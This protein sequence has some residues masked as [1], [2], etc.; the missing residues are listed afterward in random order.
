MGNDLRLE[1]CR[2][3]AAELPANDR[4]RLARHEYD[5]SD[6]IPSTKDPS[7]PRDVAGGGPVGSGASSGAPEGAVQRLVLGGEQAAVVL[8]AVDRLAGALRPIPKTP[9]SCVVAVCCA[10]EAVTIWARHRT[11]PL[12][13]AAMT[14]F[15][16]GLDWLAGWYSQVDLSGAT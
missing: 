4:G 14:V 7:I 6:L 11:W 13:D 12:V 1:R 9:R 15:R 5:P 8:D 3:I 10:D 16:I 2:A